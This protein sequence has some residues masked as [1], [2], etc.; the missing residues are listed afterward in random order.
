MA[1][2]PTSTPVTRAA[3]WASAAL[4]VLAG[5]TACGTAP[6][7]PTLHFTQPVLLLGEVHDNAAQHR[8]RLA[9]F[10]AWLASGARPALALEQFDR[11][12]QPAIDRLLAQDSGEARLEAQA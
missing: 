11:D 8:L 9:A 3:N 7:T 5:L 12:N 2:R 10:R 6:P 4:L 1:G